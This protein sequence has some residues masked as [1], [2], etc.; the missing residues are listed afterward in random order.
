VAAIIYVESRFEPSACSSKDAMGLMQITPNTGK[1]IASRLGIEKYDDKMLLDPQTNIEFGIWYLDDLRK[2]F[3][4]DI[5]LLLAAYNAGRGNV[6]QWVDSGLIKNGS[7]A[8]AIPFAE[9]RNYINKV[10]EAY[11]H[12]KK[13]YVR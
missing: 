11:E 1:W 3:K 9:T 4:G 2:E 7:D 6:K 10:M 5:Q 12:Y 8:S 13:L